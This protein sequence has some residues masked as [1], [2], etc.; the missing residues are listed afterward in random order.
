[1]TSGHILDRAT[2][3]THVS[4][5]SRDLPGL[6]SLLTGVAHNVPWPSMNPS[7]ALEGLIG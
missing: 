3:K 4:E 1:M 2:L 7:D 6:Q 5:L